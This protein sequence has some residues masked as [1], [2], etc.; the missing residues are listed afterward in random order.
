MYSNLFKNSYVMFV[1]SFI[2][3]YGLFYL[4]DIGTRVKI[5]DNKV[6]KKAGWQ[7]PLAIALIIWVIW[8]FL[9]YPPKNIKTPES[10]QSAQF[11]SPPSNIP[12]I[13]MK[14]WV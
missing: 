3:L 12:E 5:V 13:N 4:L 11:S 6:S 2:I 1:L 9:L 14:N 7:Y 8:H 10:K